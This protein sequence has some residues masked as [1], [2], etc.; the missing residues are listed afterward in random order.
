V[1]ATVLVVSSNEPVAH[2]IVREAR[3][4]GANLL[5]IGAYSHPRSTEIL[6]GGVTRSLLSNTELPMLI[7]R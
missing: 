7:S 3:G 6:F 5:V 2:T 4:V 1:S